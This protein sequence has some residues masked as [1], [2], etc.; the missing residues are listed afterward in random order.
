MKALITALALVTL[1]A[2]PS[3]AQHAEYDAPTNQSPASS[4]YGDNGW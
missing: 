1:L 3:F 4:S 2:G